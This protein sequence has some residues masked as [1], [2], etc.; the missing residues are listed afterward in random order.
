MPEKPLQ[1]TGSVSIA[2]PFNR[3]FEF[4][5][6]TSTSLL[7]PAAD[8]FMAG[9]AS[10]VFFIFIHFFLSKELST[11]TFSW[12]AYYLAFLVNYPHF[13]SS[14]QLLYGDSG[15][16]FFAFRTHWR[17]ALQLWWA[18]IIMPG[19][20]IAYMVY[21]FMQGSEQ[22]FGLTVNAMF[23]LVGWHY[24]RQIFGCVIIL[25]AAKKVYFST[26]ERHLIKAPLYTIWFLS[27]LNA[28]TYG[29]MNVFHGVSYTTY[30][31]TDQ[32]L[33]AMY[34]LLTV[35]TA[36]FLVMI[37]AKLWRQK[38]MMPISAWSA[39]IAIYLWYIP[40]L[41]HPH[42]FLIIPFF[43]SLQ[44][45]LF[46]TVYKK[47]QFAQEEE[48]ETHVHHDSK[49]FSSQALVIASVVFLVL[50]IVLSFLVYFAEFFSSF[51]VLLRQWI[52]PSIVEGPTKTVGVISA[53]GLL[54]FATLVGRRFFSHTSFAQLS[55]FM[56]Q[57]IILGALLFS[58]LPTIFDIFATLSGNLAISYNTEIFGTTLY[59]FI[60]TIF[61]NIHHYF[62]DNVLWRRDNPH[63][64]SFLKGNE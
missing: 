14:Y 17:H 15:K 43:H 20:L 22:L 34:G 33:P 38:A 63:V 55:L 6:P 3:A 7:S 11:Y 1:N 58:L 2:M 42:Y 4:F 36:V 8:I 40:S 64:K 49:F 52:G 26:L 61:I 50:P 29:Y 19:L 41:A 12:I 13:A 56:V 53:L 47:N 45:L 28:N 39:F 25:S 24:V 60:F 62:I 23:F 9:G 31:L 57:A 59:L 30:T 16:Y 18:G 37:F 5:R 48:E 27:F 54:M 35:T 32:A 46:V 10:I 21:A 44:Y 51:E